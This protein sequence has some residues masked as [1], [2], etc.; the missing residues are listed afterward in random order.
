MN[1]RLSAYGFALVLLTC[2]AA[3]ALTK[4]EV[5]C[6][7]ALNKDGAA[8]GQQ[9]GKENL[10][11]LKGAG[12]A[13]LTG[14]AQ[15]CLT[16]DAKGK[17]AKKAEKTTADE[18]KLC[19]DAP[20]FAY[21]SA[22]T[23]NA[24]SRQAE[25]DLV[26]D[27]FGPDLDAAVASCDTSAKAC[28][29]QNAVLGGVEKT[30]KTSRAA[31]L[32]CKKAALGTAD[33]AEDVA[34]CIADGA[35][36]TSIAAERQADGKV[37]K[38]VVKLGDAIAKKCDT[39]MVTGGAFP[40]ACTALTGDALRDCLDGRIACRVCESL[41]AA[42][43]LAVDCDAFDDGVD[44]ASCA[45]LVCAAGS[46]APCYSGPPGTLNVGICTAGTQV[47]NGSGTGYG[48]CSGQVVPAV[49]VCGD[50]LDNDCDG[51][52][53]DG[54]LGDRAWNDINANGV[55]DPGEPGLAGA[56][57]ILRTQ[58]GAVVGVAVSSATGTYGFTNV[59]PGNYYVEVIPPFSFEVTLKDAGGDDTLD[60]DFDSSSGATDVFT[61]SG[62]RS[63]IDCGMKS[64]V[65]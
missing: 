54:C 62:G 58:I 50:G 18:A 13:D 26:E 59:S 41:G 17:V 60:G 28:K 22:S 39:P 44:N 63:D 15:A 5:K 33:G 65:P 48:S 3:A 1:V 20:D 64:V 42:D 4:D 55:Q 19:G 47:C 35:T 25:L 30:A 8:V 45:T 31:F 37:A 61:F 32:K 21:T 27:V 53:D 10:A 6:V 46:T 12:K 14:T 49:D 7:S 29:C 24:V 56:T 40:G 16:A 34:A 43:G 36:T 57:F 23:V 38:E 51:I 11:C 52:P 9:Q 2:T